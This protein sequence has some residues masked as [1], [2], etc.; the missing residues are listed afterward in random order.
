MSIL[1][2]TCGSGAF[3]C[4]AVNTLEPLYT[5]CLQRLQSITD[6][7]THLSSSI[8]SQHA[9]F[10]KKE[11]DD[12]HA[13]L[14]KGEE[15]PTQRHFILNTL[16]SHN[17]YG[18]DIMKE[19]TDLCQ[20]RLFLALAASSERIEDVLPFSSIQWNIMTGNAL[21]GPIHSPGRG[22][23]Q[24]IP[25]PPHPHFHW[26]ETFPDVMK[27]GGFAIIIG[28]PPYVEYSK[29]RQEYNVQGYETENCGNLYAAVLE[30]ALTLCRTGTSYLGLIVPLS[31]CGGERFT[32]LR[33][34]MTGQLAELWLANFEIFPSRLFEGAFQRLSIVIAHHGSSTQDC[35]IHTTRIQR[36]YAAERPY[37]IDLMNYTPT[38]LTIKADVFPKLASPLQETILHKLAAKAQGHNIASVLYPRKTEHFVYYQEAT[39]YWMKATCTVP[40]YKKN[41]AVMEPGHGRFLYFREQRMAHVVMAVMNSSLFYLWF[42]TFSDGFHLSHA[43]VKEFPLG[44]S[45]YADEDLELLAI[46]LEQDIRLHTRIST[47]NTKVHSIELEE[48]RMSMS[49]QLLDE[50]DGV[51]GRYY[52]LSDEEM[53]F[54]V[55]YDRKYRMGKE[56]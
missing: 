11:L 34:T 37:L 47:R 39:N 31:V 24:D 48:Y 19:A 49:K 43:L 54:V 32:Q 27:Q 23:G 5:F 7:D 4:A 8:T 51:L 29:V 22:K 15:Y 26:S 16:L 56:E 10:H 30:R 21:L 9:C 50:I 38:H 55:E 12:Y 20:L 2:P 6:N 40:Y 3:L 44:S 35:R 13:I 46:K 14:K 52:G 36:W 28:N 42:A 53:E 17:L 41:G 45:L 1:D 18:V 25:R 33:R